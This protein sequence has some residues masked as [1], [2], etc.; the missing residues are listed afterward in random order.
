MGAIIADVWYGTRAK[1]ITFPVGQSM[2][3]SANMTAPFF[4]RTKGPDWLTLESR[5][6]GH[7]EIAPAGRFALHLFGHMHENEIVYVSI[8]GGSPI[9]RCQSR[10]VFGMEHFGDPPVKQR[11]HG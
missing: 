1:S 7:S 8:G 10:S 6:H 2:I 5:Q 9:R 11:S 4:S 3:G